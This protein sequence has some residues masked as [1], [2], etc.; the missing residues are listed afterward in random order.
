MN[1]NV[2]WFKSWFNSKYYHILYK[3]RSKSEADLFINNIISQL[4]LDYSKSLLDLGCGKGRHAIKLS[5]YF[6]NVDGLDLSDESIKSARENHKTNLNFHIGDMR[7]F[8]LGK[9]YRYIFNLF[10]SFGYFEKTSDNIS[11]LNCCN[12]HLLKDGYLLIDFL[13]PKKIKKELVRQEV[14]VIDDI[15][16]NISKYI[17]DEFVIKNISI[18]DNNNRIQFQERVQLFEIE[19]FIEMLN[20]TGFKLISSFGNYHLDSYNDNSERLIIWAK[21][22]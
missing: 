8:N 2:D 11:V 20:K 4:E 3:N 22:I 18:L 14:K 6:S 1:K 13:N 19:K 5:E 9:K 21:K 7:D 17:Q 10:T 15:V 12:K 16:F